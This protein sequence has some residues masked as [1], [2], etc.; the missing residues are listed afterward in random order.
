MG[1]E[2]T[3]RGRESARKIFETDDGV[4]KETLGY[5]VKEES[6]RNRLRVKAEKTAT[7]F[8]DKMNGREECTIL[9]ECWRK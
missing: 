4:E 2:G 5:I 8:E 1:M 9:T 6:K 3:R 7:K